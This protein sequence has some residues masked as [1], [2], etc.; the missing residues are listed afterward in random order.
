MGNSTGEVSVLLNSVLR[1]VDR[2]RGHG[3]SNRIQY[4]NPEMDR[5][6]PA[7]EVKLD[8]TRREAL[9]REV[10]QVVLTDRAMR[11][12]RHQCFIRTCRSCTARR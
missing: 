12:A 9:L 3:S 8:D 11:H 2:A 6:L 5:L 1:T 7:A 10:T 4:S